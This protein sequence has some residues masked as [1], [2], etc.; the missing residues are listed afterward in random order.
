M[1]NSEELTLVAVNGGK[2]DEFRKIKPI[3]YVSGPL[4]ACFPA[5]KRKLSSPG[6]AVV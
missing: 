4:A 2:G 1:L 6:T 3:Y 5:F